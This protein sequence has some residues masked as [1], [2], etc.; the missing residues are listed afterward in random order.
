[1]IRSPVVTVAQLVESQV[2]ALVAVGSSP[3]SHPKIFP[4][5]RP[6]Y[7]PGLFDFLLLHLETYKRTLTGNDLYDLDMK[8]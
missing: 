1:M 4:A 7:M 2:V 5:K 3:I 8:T 6:G